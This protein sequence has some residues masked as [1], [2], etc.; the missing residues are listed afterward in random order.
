MAS[1]HHTS[2]VLRSFNI[3]FFGTDHFAIPSLRRLVQKSK[4]NKELISELTVIT[5]PDATSGRGNKILKPAPIK[6]E[7]IGLGLAVHHPPP[8]KF[9]AWELP[10]SISNRPY[11]LAIA[12][13]FG[14]FIPKRILA[15]FPYGGVNVHPSLLPKYRG[16]APLLHTL[17]NG[18]STTGV[19]VQEL[20]VQSFDAGRILNQCETPVSPTEDYLTLHNRLSEKGA[21]MLV[22]TLERWDY[23]QANG[24]E[25]DPTKVSHSPKLDRTCSFVNWESDSPELIMRRY[26]SLGWRVSQMQ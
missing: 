17:W 10:P 25:Q 18:D 9:G 14:Y 2:C 8:K 1:M 12:V 11:D 23:F 6:L 20:S 7:A 13:S 5:P 4:E 3:A 15:G 24:W 19:T 22:D 26:L 16:A 21:Q